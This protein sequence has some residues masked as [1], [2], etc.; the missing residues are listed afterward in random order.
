MTSRISVI[1]SKIMKSSF[2]FHSTDFLFFHKTESKTVTALKI[3]HQE[4][5]TE[6]KAVFAEC[7][8][9]FHN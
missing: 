1:I 6:Q 7:P 2:D 5:G 9:L 8:A 4:E 3:H